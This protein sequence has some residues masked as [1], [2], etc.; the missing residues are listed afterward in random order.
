MK[1]TVINYKKASTKYVDAGGGVNAPQKKMMNMPLYVV[2]GF[3]TYN[4][5]Q[6]CISFNRADSVKRKGFS[7]KVNELAYQHNHRLFNKLIK[8]VD[9]Y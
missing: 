4:G 2:L 9:L 6:A 7:K 5:L 8:P 3:S 1:R